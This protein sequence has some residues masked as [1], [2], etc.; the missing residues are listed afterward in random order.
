[1]SLVRAWES[2]R[3]RKTR[4][5]IVLDFLILV[6][7]VVLLVPSL[8]MGVMVNVIRITLRQPQRYIEQTKMLIPSWLVFSDSD[9]RVVTLPDTL[10]RPILINF[11]AT[12]SPQ[13]RAEMKSLNLF[14]KI[15]G[16]YV[17]LYVVFTEERDEVER[18]ID[19]FD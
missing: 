7:V 16:D 1:M 2:Y 15:Y 11:A 4:A 14:E 13:S 5:G 19:G 9:G 3:N 17:D 6:A 10:S 12:W 8:R 18:Y